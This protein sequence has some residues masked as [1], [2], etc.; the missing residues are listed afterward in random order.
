MVVML[1]PELVV[2]LCSFQPEFSVSFL[3]RCFSGP[4][5]DYQRP[6][7]RAGVRGPDQVVSWEV[8]FS[9]FQFLRRH[10]P[11]LN[12]FWN[13][14]SH[15][16]IVHSAEYWMHS[17]KCW[18]FQVSPC[19]CSV[20]LLNNGIPQRVTS[21][22]QMDCYSDLL[23]FYLNSNWPRHRGKEALV[24]AVQLSTSQLTGHSGFKN[25]HPLFSKTW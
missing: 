25:K 7:V 14:Q 6:D 11:N 22:W 8:D 24:R 16:T 15:Y 19:K 5:L 9:H 4:R 2:E 17:S 21:G 12:N 1:R 20:F 3:E 13:L 23:R 18:I 10:C